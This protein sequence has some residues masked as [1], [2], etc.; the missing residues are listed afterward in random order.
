MP[1]FVPRIWQNMYAVHFLFPST[2]SIMGAAEVE[3]H[4]QLESDNIHCCLFECCVCLEKWSNTCCCALSGHVTSW[5]LMLLSVVSLLLLSDSVRQLSNTAAWLV[6]QIHDPDVHYPVHLISACA[7][8]RS[9]TETM[10]C[11]VVT[12]E[13]KARRV[14]QMAHKDDPGGK[15]HRSKKLQSVTIAAASQGTQLELHTG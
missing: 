7:A 9:L 3:E 4:L 2:S 10:S 14:V 13:H 6:N 1:P 8:R 5:L 12:Q 15:P 11:L